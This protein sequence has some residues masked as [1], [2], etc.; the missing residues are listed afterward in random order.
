[1]TGQR[2][3]SVASLL[4]SNEPLT[5]VEAGRIRKTLADAQ[6]SLASVEARIAGLQKERTI[7]EQVIEEH[8]V[9]LSPLRS[10]ATEILSEILLFSAGLPTTLNTKSGAWT[11]SKVSHRWRDIVVSLPQFWSSVSIFYQ[12]KVPRYALSIV[13]TIL[14]RSGDATLD[15]TFEVP[16]RD[17]A[18]IRAWGPLLDLLASAS[19]RWRAIKFIGAFSLT[20]YLSQVRG[21]VPRLEKL[22]LH[23]K[24]KDHWHVPEEMGLWDLWYD[25][26][27]LRRV[28]WV[29]PSNSD[30]ARVIPLKL[31]WP[32][33][34]RFD[35]GVVGPIGLNVLGSASHL[36]HLT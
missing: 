28:E 29:A 9:V 17:P 2:S 25:A 16:S 20:E 4:Q 27:R 33:I 15:I 23:I 34:T 35:T 3:A 32:Q 6:S 30:L 19:L 26:P 5:A 1:M 13:H 36:T 10:L 24:D 7:L 21:H 14:C 18:D 22:S 8:K 11:L 12:S 31:P